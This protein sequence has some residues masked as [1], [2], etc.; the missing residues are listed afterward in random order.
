[1]HTKFEPENVKDREY[2]ENVGIDG[3]TILKWILN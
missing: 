1:M 3:D 2:V